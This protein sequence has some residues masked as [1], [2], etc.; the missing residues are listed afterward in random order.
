[1]ESITFIDGLWWHRQQVNGSTTIPHGA[2]MLERAGN[3]DN[4]RL[5]AG[6]P[7]SADH[8]RGPVFMDSDIHKW[9]EAIS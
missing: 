4:M 5:A 3:L 9:L 8:F 6:L 1:M 7:T 2:E